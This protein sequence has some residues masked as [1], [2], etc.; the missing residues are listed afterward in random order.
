MTPDEDSRLKIVSHVRWLYPDNGPNVK[1]EIFEVWHDDDYVSRHSTRDEAETAINSL[2]ECNKHST[3]VDT[4]GSCQIH[5]HRRWL[6][7]RE[8]EPRLYSTYEIWRGMEYISG[9]ATRAKAEAALAKL[10]LHRKDN[11]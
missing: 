5:V 6:Y 4:T 9:H 7:L 10:K 1:Q 3:P 11:A 8:D 2:R